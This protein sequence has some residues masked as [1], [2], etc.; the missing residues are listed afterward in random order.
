MCGVSAFEVMFMDDSGV[1]P[2]S[3]SPHP[4]PVG[5]VKMTNSD[6]QSPREGT[7]SLGVKLLVGALMIV[8]MIVSLIIILSGTFQLVPAN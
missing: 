8:L 4:V 7:S 3:D 6:S 2:G 5:R 1:K